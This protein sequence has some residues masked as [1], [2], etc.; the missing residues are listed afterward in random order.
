MNDKL[1]AD[2]RAALRTVATACVCQK[3]RVAARAL[4]RFY[5]RY[6]AGSEIEPT[7]F[8]LLVAV[9]LSEPV[10]LAAL[11][12]HLGLER[13][14]L[15]RNLGLLQRDGL[16]RIDRGDDARQ[17]L[18]SLTQAGRRAL[19]RSMT[20]WKR[21]QQAAMSVLG[22]EDFAR[23]SEALSLSNKFTKN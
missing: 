22:K 16:V 8:D 23:L 14:T 2:E 15:T 9:R 7:Q 17:R 19:K 4:T 21:A 3:A 6:F 20:Y 5:D 10:P 11:A 18:L 12:G 13:T 1:S